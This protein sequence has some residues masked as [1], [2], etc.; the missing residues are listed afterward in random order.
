M[1]ALIPIQI[2]DI[3]HR[4]L[5]RAVVA[6]TQYHSP[7]AIVHFGHLRSAHAVSFM[8]NRCAENMAQ[9]RIH[10]SSIGQPCFVTRNLR[11]VQHNQAPRIAAVKAVGISHVQHEVATPAS[12]QRTDQHGFPL[13]ANFHVTGKG[14]AV[15]IE[16]VL[17]LRIRQFVQCRYHA[18]GHVGNTL[19]AVFGRKAVQ[20]AVV[21]AHIYHGI[22][23]RS[24]RTDKAQIAGIAITAG[25]LA[26]I[27][28]VGIDNIALA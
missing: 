18:F 13:A 14:G 10:A 7:A 28:N 20:H 24:R 12:T 5:I 16:F 15:H 1:Y 3:E 8:R 17:V 19:L 26:H 6:I 25:R 22:I 9:I 2:L 11:G 21:T 27:P 23:C 4:L